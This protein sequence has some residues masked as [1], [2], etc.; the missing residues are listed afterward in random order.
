MKIKIY[1]FTNIIKVIIFLLINYIDIDPTNNNNNNENIIYRN[2]GENKK[3]LN[4]SYS[5]EKNQSNIDKKQDILLEQEIFRVKNILENLK[6]T[7][8]NNLLL[9][10]LLSEKYE[11]LNEKQI[12]EEKI[13]EKIKN[14]NKTKQK[15]HVKYVKYTPLNKVYYYC[16]KKIHYYYILMDLVIKSRKKNKLGNNNFHISL[17]GNNSNIPKKK[18]INRFKF[19]KKED[20]ILR[21]NL[22]LTLQYENINWIE[23]ANEIQNKNAFQV[24]VRSLEISNFYAY[25][26]WTYLED[27]ILRKAI[28]YYGPKNWQQISYCLD[29]RNNSQCFHRWMKGINPKIKRDKWSFE[30][31]LTL[32]VALKIYGNKKWSKIANH[33]TGRTDIQCRERFCNI[34]DPNLEEVE[35]KSSE[36]IKLLS[37]FEKY[38]KKWSKI[39]KE[40]GNRTDNTCWRRWKYLMSIKSFNNNNIINNNNNTNKIFSNKDILKTN[41]NSNSLA[42]FKIKKEK[43]HFSKGK[44]RKNLDLNMNN[45]INNINNKKIFESFSNNNILNEKDHL[46]NGK[47]NIN[48]KDTVRDNIEIT[49]SKL[50]S[51]KNETQFLKKKLNRGINIIISY[52][53]YLIL[54]YHIY[55]IRWKKI[56]KK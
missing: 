2:S 19:N 47:N 41:N 27:S 25:K 49:N 1:I 7:K 33:L 32:G 34:L 8:E 11:K 15:K 44:K 5:F 3:N 39:A 28:L 24:F 37:L 50:N 17:G 40:F 29:G 23:I 54:F 26:K 20:S 12:S 4:F 9:Q 56:E 36:D 35:W 31:D 53:V 10:K 48:I 46:N 55:L 42:N 22:I 16:P 14:I 6:K 43:R 38:G 30:E 51:K 13:L 21:K 45:S 18:E 52:F